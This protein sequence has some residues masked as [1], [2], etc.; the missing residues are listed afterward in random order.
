M[1][2]G[3]P[4]PAAVRLGIGQPALGEGGLAVTHCLPAQSLIAV[5]DGPEHVPFI[6]GGDLLGSGL[7]HLDRAR[8]ELGHRDPLL[9]GDVYEWV[10][11]ISQ[12]V[13]VPLDP[14]QPGYE[15]A[16]LR[17]VRNEV[18][19]NAPETQLVSVSVV[20]NASF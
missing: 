9:L 8:V 1:G 11:V 19:D 10:L 3:L 2:V 18:D 14:E 7:S 17:V 20:Q 16:G 15:V 5:E 4:I 6:E 13:L 12:R